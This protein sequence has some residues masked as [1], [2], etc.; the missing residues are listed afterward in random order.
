MLKQFSN[1]NLFIYNATDDV[2]E[3]LNSINEFKPSWPHNNKLVGLN[4]FFM[5]HIGENNIFMAN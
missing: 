4:K 2:V 5:D 1:A 3:E